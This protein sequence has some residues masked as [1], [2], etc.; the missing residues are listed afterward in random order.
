MKTNQKICLGLLTLAFFLSLMTFYGNIEA[1]ERPL[2]ITQ[3]MDVTSFDPTSTS[4]TPTMNFYWNIYDS[5]VTWD[6]KEPTKLV[7]C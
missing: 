1:Q 2:V 5:L 3:A 6:E 7:P 4:H